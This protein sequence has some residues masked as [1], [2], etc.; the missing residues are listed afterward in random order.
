MTVV[1][2]GRAGPFIAA[3]VYSAVEGDS[4]GCRVELATP[5]VVT[6]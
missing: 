2:P 5:A 4:V 3:P 6:G 1:A